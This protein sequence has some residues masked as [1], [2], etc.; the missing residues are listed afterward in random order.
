MAEEV[1]QEEIVLA[2]RLDGRQRNRLKGLLDMMYTPRELS[3]EIG[4]NVN[5]VYMVYIHGG[6]PHERDEVRRIW[7]N[8]QAFKKWYEEVYAKRSLK[9]REA[10]CLTCKCPVEMKNEVRRQKEKMIYYLCECPNCGR[11]LARIVDHKK[12]FV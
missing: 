3:E 10:F 5:R 4:V 1:S 12:K 2:G 11:K 9:P 8:G 6:C 7:I